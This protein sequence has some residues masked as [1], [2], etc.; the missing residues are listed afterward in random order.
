ME[1]GGSASLETVEPPVRVN[2]ELA[3]QALGSIHRL[4]SYVEGQDFA[5]YDP[6][7]GLNSPLIQRLCFGKK[8]VRI[9]WIQLFRRSLI[10]LRPL[11]GV[12]PGHNPKGIGLCL[13]AYGRMHRL[14]PER[15]SLSR[16]RALLALLTEL[17]S[18][19]RTGNGW[20]YNFDWQNRAFFIPRFTPT[21]VNSAFIGHALLDVH[22]ET[23]LPESLDLAIPIA[24]FLLGDLHRTREGET[25]CFSYTPLDRTAVHNA[26]LLGASL[27]IRL[28]RVTGRDTLRDAALA[29][30]EYSM[31]HQHPDGSWYYAEA[32]GQQWIDSFHTG[33]NLQAIRWFLALGEAGGWRAAYERGVEYYAT[34]FFLE[35]GTPKYYDDRVYPIDI[36]APAQAIAFFSGEGVRHGPLVDRILA[37][38]LREMQHPR[39]CF[40]FRKGRGWTNRISYMRWSQAWMLHALSG[41]LANVFA[42]SDSANRWGSSQARLR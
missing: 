17:R 28:A 34:R 12:R 40:F 2:T 22:L 1:D 3:R 25:F 15:W 13:W 4:A 36:H 33:F 31:N 19:G 32:P 9:A 38:T 35:D 42:A 24:D 30:M 26:N 20:G 18:R 11:V 7:D 39:G 37:W 14:D 27:L 29:S 21:I 41:Y 16:V 5:G 8:W 6:Y 10:N 23:G